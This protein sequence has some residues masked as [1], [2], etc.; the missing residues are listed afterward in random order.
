MYIHNTYIYIYIYIYIIDMY[1]YMLQSWHES[2]MESVVLFFF[3]NPAGPTIRR[4]CSSWIIEAVFSMK[5]S[6]VFRCSELL[7]QEKSNDWN[8]NLVG[9]FIMW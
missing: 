3:K 5:I 8:I 2:S 6:K 1:T 7:V 9:I 4:P